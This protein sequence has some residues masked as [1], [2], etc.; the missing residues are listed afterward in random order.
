M[1]V[2]TFGIPVVLNRVGG[3]SELRYVNGS[4]LCPWRY[5]GHWDLYVPVDHT[6]QAFEEFCEQAADVD[7][8]A[9]TGRLVVVSG[10]EGSGKTALIHRCVYILQRGLAGALGVDPDQGA[11]GD[12]WA[13][14]PPVPG[15]S[16]VD[17]S[18]EARRVAYDNKGQL[19]PL[20]AINQ[21]IFKRV[22]GDVRKQLSN[23]AAQLE[24]LASDTSGELVDLYQE[25]SDFLC[26]REHFMLVILPFVRLGTRQ[27]H[28]DFLRSYL[29]FSDRRIVFFAET[30]EP[31]VMTSMAPTLSW[32][33][34]NLVTHLSIGRLDDADCESFVRSRMSRPGLP[35]EHVIIAPGTLAG[36][37]PDVHYETVRRLQDSFFQLGEIVRRDGRNEISGDDFKTLEEQRRNDPRLL[38][39]PRPRRG[40]GSQG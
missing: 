4:P 3:T 26:D 2:N 5:R 17:L 1:T 37:A 36:V 31:D 9:A 16:V 10:V 15:V 40:R 33:E 22:V 21:K 30:A 27:L 8:L 24:E 34:R 20:D 18:D 25:L 13:L 6:Q 11:A 29:N 32:E 23:P 7:E 38:R 39:R 14:R 35:Q 19:C 28:V 12:K